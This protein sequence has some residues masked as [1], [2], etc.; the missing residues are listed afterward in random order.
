MLACPFYVILCCFQ[1]TKHTSY[2]HILRIYAT[3]S[4]FDS[5]LSSFYLNLAV[6]CNDEIIFKLNWNSIREWNMLEKVIRKLTTVSDCGIFSVQRATT[7]V[8]WKNSSATRPN[9][10][11]TLARSQY[12]R[13]LSKSTVRTNLPTKS[14]MSSFYHAQ[15]ISGQRIF[16][17]HASMVNLAAGYVDS[18]FN[19]LKEA[20][21]S[22]INYA[23]SCSMTVSA[24]SFTIT[25]C[26]SMQLKMSLLPSEIMKQ[27][28]YAYIGATAGEDM[29][30]LSIRF[31]VVTRLNDP[32]TPNILMKILG[33]T[34][35]QYLINF[36]A[37]TLDI[38]GKCL[39][40]HFNFC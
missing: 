11:R 29:T 4:R 8:V 27:P 35:P 24:T 40:D 15:R 34:F 19:E 17:G 5:F 37:K 22:K 9:R 38:Q 1:F 6:F 12:F 18:T 7:D 3:V 32:V 14:K 13:D 31:K 26:I 23:V 20:L 16:D 2:S 36:D 25:P 21:D 30:S 39:P 10:K 33:K 28:R